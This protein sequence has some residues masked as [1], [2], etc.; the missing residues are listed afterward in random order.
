MDI[1]IIIVGAIILSAI[2]FGGITFA[3]KTKAF[4]AKNDCGADCGCNRSDK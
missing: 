3:R 1:Q 2:A 4:S